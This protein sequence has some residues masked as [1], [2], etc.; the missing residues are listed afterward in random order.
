[1]VTTVTKGEKELV[2]EVINAGLCAYC[3]ACAG[4]CPYLVPNKGKMVM[5]DNCTK[6]GGQCYEYC[7]RTSTDMDALSRKLFDAPYNGSEMGTVSEVLMARSA[8]PGV[9]AKAQY[10]G[11][12]TALLVLAK[13]E[14]LIDA[15]ILSRTTGD[16][17]PEAIVANSVAEIMECAGS[18]YMACPVVEK[19]NRLPFDGAPRVGVVAMPCQAVA[20]GKM[21]L[22]PP[23]NRGDIGNLKFVIGLFC[24]WALSAD[25]FHKFL[26]DNLNL[27]SVT[28]FDIP[29]PP[30]NVFNAY[31]ASGKVA[32]SLDQVR[33]YAMPT[34]AYCTDM[35]SEFTDI[36]VGSVEGIEDWNTVIVRS[37]AG[38]R[39]LKLAKTKKVLETGELP[40]ANLAHLKEAALIK[41]KRA[42]REIVKK[43]GSRDNLMYLQL[44]R[45]T[46]DKLL[47]D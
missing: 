32:L 3:G 28:R 38:A 44:P 5:M 24:T 26:K 11:V 33:K 36:S 9:R 31:T 15:A 18:N 29:P 34:C 25:T 7:P 8:D 41:K 45:A 27:P 21:K 13:R 47:A 10:G 20:L 40:A 22:Q 19:Y 12:V 23:R 4:A 14:G 46:A 35:T 1:M 43:T 37:D 39:L 42:L 2:A 6:T 16:K 30:A 17:T